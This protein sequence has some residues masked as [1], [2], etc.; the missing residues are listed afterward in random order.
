MKLL[1]G[2]M[3]AATLASQLGS[4]SPNLHDDA[5]RVLAALKRDG[6][7]PFT[8]KDV[9]AILLAMGAGTSADPG[10]EKVLHG[11]SWLTIGEAINEVAVKGEGR[12]YYNFADIAA[13]PRPV[14]VKAVKK[15]KKVV[16]RSGEPTETFKWFERQMRDF[17]LD[18][19]VAA[20]LSRKFHRE[21]YDDLLSEV[22]LWFT[23][24]SNK[25]TCDQY[26]LDGKP[27]TVTILTVWVGQKIIHRMARDGQD[28][29]RRETMGSRTQLEVQ[30]RRDGSDYI[31]EKARK[32][33]PNAPRAIWVGDGEGDGLHREFIAPE[34]V[35]VDL[36]EIFEE[37][38]LSLVR[39]IVRVRRRRAADRYARFF[40][41]LMNRTSKEEAAS[42]EG[43][44]ELRVTHLY[45]RVR[46]D[47]RD[48]PIL[49]E[50]ALKVLDIITAEPYSTLKEIEV[51][52]IPPQISGVPA[53]LKQALSLLVMRGLATEAQGSSYAPTEAGRKALEAQS[54]V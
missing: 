49:I 38:E 46:D 40:D 45:Q 47:L 51:D 37:G 8:R 27:P 20:L 31:S 3:V 12:G 19:K 23:K 4:S 48:A 43:V 21:D 7:N 10:T 16:P 29:L 39:D 18:R 32:M 28:A 34:E 14:K 44:S 26:I 22:H 11:A 25:G 52:V 41:H 15:E 36:T 33:D 50:V 5:L 6:H 24:W 54:L 9:T 42:L 53:D 1:L 17:A 13:R 30:S 2:P 35:L